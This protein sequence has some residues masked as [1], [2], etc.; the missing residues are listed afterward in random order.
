MPY[1]LVGSNGDE[2]GPVE[3]ETLVAWAKDGRVSPRSTVRVTPAGESV[4]A[5]TIPELGLVDLP[6]KAVV[7][8]TENYAHYPR[9]ENL[10]QGPPSKAGL[11][12]SLFWSGL[13]IFLIIFTDGLGYILALLGLLDVFRAWQRK[14]PYFRWIAGIVSLAALVAMWGIMFKH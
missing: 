11:I 10:V 5:H 3:L 6:P 4:L 12:S 1:V 2:Y 13:A 7:P 9:G 14:D 8:P